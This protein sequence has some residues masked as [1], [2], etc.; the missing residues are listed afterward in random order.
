VRLERLSLPPAP[1]DVLS[2][3]RI[4][5]L[6]NK[7]YYLYLTR[8]HVEERPTAENGAF[9]LRDRRCNRYAHIQ[10]VS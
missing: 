5:E 8:N 6:A 9:E 10:K 1:E 4:L 2:A 7:A 3:Q